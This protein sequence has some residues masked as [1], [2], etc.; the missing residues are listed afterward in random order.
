MC[1]YLTP[2]YNKSITTKEVTPML[3]SALTYSYLT[4]LSHS[5]LLEVEALCLATQDT[6]TLA[7]IARIREWADPSNRETV[8]APAAPA[9]PVGITWLNAEVEDVD[10]GDTADA[11]PWR[12]AL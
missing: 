1:L 6:N 7:R 10:F 11:D 12:H 2:C 9:R 4:S 5:E 8:A 3:N